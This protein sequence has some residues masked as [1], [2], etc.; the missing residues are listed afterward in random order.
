VDSFS[1]KIVLSLFLSLAFLTAVA[2]IWLPRLLEQPD[3]NSIKGLEAAPK[4]PFSDD[5]LSRVVTRFPTR[6]FA[7]QA[8]PESTSTEPINDNEPTDNP[9]GQ[10]TGGLPSRI[11]SGVENTE[12]LGERVTTRAYLRSNSTVFARPQMTAEVL[13][14][15]GTETKVRWLAKIGDGWE[16]ILLKDGRSAYVQSKNM[17]FSADSWST[18]QTGFENR[19]ASVSP[20]T[21]LLPSTVETFL[22]HLSAGDA[23]RAE[24]FLSPLAPRLDSETLGTLQPYLGAPPL[25]RVLRIE[26]ISGDR[27]SHRRVR[28]V[29]GPEM[30]HEAATL[31]EWDVTQQ[32]WMLVRWE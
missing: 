9:S 22:T 30:S 26:V 14:S 27:A 1:R 3:G 25:G 8:K 20:D 18:H 21:A 28:V 29:Y 17:S 5:E 24:T 19:G 6:P 13:G 4:A 10:E 7:R 31:W 12:A 11:V 2:V 16:E 15:V 23:L 32:R